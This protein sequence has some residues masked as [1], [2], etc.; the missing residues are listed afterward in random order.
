MNVERTHGGRTGFGRDATDYRRDLTILTIPRLSLF[1]LSIAL[2][3]AP[4]GIGLTPN[5]AAA[6][7]PRDSCDL[8]C[9]TDPYWY[10]SN[11]WRE[12]QM[13]VPYYINQDGATTCT[14]DEFS[15]VQ[16]SAKN[17]E[18]LHQ[19]F[20]STCYKG[21]TNKH[22]AAHQGSPAKDG[23]NVIS[24]EDLGGGTPLPLGRSFYWYGVSGDS[25]IEADVSLNNNAAVS[26]SAFKAD[27]CAAGYHDVENTTTHEFG[28]WF[29]L[30]H[31]CDTSATMYCY[32]KERETHR[33]SPEECD[34]LGMKGKYT[35][36]AGDARIEPGCWPVSLDDDILTNP[37]LGDVNRDGAEEIVFATE[38]G[39]VH[40][41]LT[42]GG[43]QYG[44]PQTAGSRIESSPVLGD[45]DGDGW[46][47]VVVGSESDSVYVFNHDGS[48]LANWPKG[49]KND[50]RSSPAIGDIDADG[51][52]DVVCASTDSCVYVWNGFTGA[53]IEGWPV[54]TG[55]VIPLAGPALADLNADDS[56]EVIISG[57]DNYVYALKSHGAN[58]TGWPQFT[59]RRVYER[60][61]V[62]DIDGDGQFEVVAV[63][64]CDTI[65]AWNT[66]GSRCAGWP[67]Y[68][69]CLLGNSAPSLGN[70]DAD[71]ALE[72]VFGSDVDS[73]YAYNGDGS[74]LSGWP[75]YVGGNVKGS[76]LIVDIDADN[77]YEVVAVT[78]QGKMY[79][80]NG[81]GSAVSGN[82][83]KGLPQQTYVRSPAIGDINGDSELD[84]VAGSGN[85]SY[86]FAYSLGTVMDSDA[87]QW[88][89]YGHDWNRTSRYGFAPPDPNVLL[90]N[91]VIADLNHWQRWGYGSSGVDLSTIYSSPPYSMCLSGSPASGSGAV[92]QSE[93]INPDFSRPYELR[94]AFTY[95][96]VMMNNWIVFG[97]VRLRLMDMNAPLFIDIAGNWSNL[98]PTGSPFN[99]YCFPGAFT[100]FR[101]TVDPVTRSVVV[102]ADEY[103]VAGA[104]Y[105]PSLVPSNRILIEDSMYEDEY[106]Y[107][108]YDD[109]EVQG[110][111]SAATGVKGAPPEAPLLNVLYQGYPNPMNPLATIN[112]SVKETGRV[113]LRIYDVSGRTVRVLVDE[114]KQA[115]PAPYSVVWDGKNDSGQQVASGVYFCEMKA[116]RFNSAKKIVVLR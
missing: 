24:W 12:G 74:R 61:A 27:S 106:L 44:W 11:H 26:W 22:S 38:D 39:K 56:L 78:D 114:E 45:A 75:K 73:V 8:G 43:E 33:R 19:T 80:F 60:V 23:Y 15:A 108:F 30:G 50:V 40:V 53:L 6:G 84:V 77:A 71:A 79:A 116:K 103:P 64:P 63:A 67:V 81:N 85:P 86:L 41:I 89:M 96:G 109:F 4:L 34:V 72:I 98:I 70:L 101:I 66:N 99:S 16:R 112:Y 110:F 2:A 25:I 58:L 115:S 104:E 113:T 10:S 107:G 5:I 76:A 97:H 52:L 18:D 54:K 94:F 68:L 62:G 46:L 3:F 28:H 17:W 105:L 51:T 55:G 14:G 29:D 88:R 82:W 92:A 32:T 83:P 90:F 31:S 57:Y 20:W 13:P 42:R 1:L 48:R 36:A 95:D 7:C 93:L 21:T 9:V 69:P 47:E 65:Y 87:Y 59:G 49:T 37:V 102:Y 111:L 100:Q 35:H 91:D